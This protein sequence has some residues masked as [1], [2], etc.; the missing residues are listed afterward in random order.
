MALVTADQAAEKDSFLE[1]PIFATLIINW[2]LVLYSLIFIT[3]DGQ[4]SIR[5]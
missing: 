4:G 5:G 1:K 2:E 3:N